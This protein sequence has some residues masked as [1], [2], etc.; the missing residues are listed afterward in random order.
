VAS[1]TDRLTAR[2]GGGSPPPPPRLDGP[3]ARPWLIS[4]LGTAG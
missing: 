3:Y 1:R 2:V 4:T